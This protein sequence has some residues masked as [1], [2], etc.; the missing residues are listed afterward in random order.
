MLSTKKDSQE[1]VIIFFV[2][3]DK[4]K[5]IANKCFKNNWKNGKLEIEVKIIM[6]AMETAARKAASVS[7]NYMLLQTVSEVDVSGIVKKDMK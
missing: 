3:S 4:T 5:T 2:D 6:L 1:I 7:K